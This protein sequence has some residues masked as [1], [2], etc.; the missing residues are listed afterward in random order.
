M[1]D[2]TEPDQRLKLT[3]A[4]DLTSLRQRSPAFK[5]ESFPDPIHKLFSTSQ[6]D[7]ADN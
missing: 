6:P 1:L 3:R 4:F 7:D 2:C 5:W